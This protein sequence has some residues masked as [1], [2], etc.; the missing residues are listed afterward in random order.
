MNKCWAILFLGLSLSLAS[1][2]TLAQQVG[3]D[4]EV[5]VAP[6]Y[7]AE[8]GNQESLY[9]KRL[10]HRAL[11][12]TVP[13]YG[14]FELRLPEQLLV[15]NRLRVSVQRGVVD[16]MWRNSVERADNGLLRVPVSLLGELTQYRMLLVRERDLPLYTDPLALSDLR[17]RVAGV[18]AQW[19]DVK[20]LA[21]NQ[22][23]YVTATGYHPL[24]R[25]LAADRFDYF[26]RG[27]YQVRGEI[28]QY[29]E[30][31]LAMVPNL[32]L[33]YPND[34][35]FYV[36]PDNPKLAKR[37]TLGLERAQRDGSLDALIDEFDRLRWAKEQISR[38]DW[39]VIY[40][41]SPLPA[42]QRR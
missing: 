16:V 10:L 5:I 4:V 32:V 30:L 40:L 11:Q 35:Y 9:F 34:V 15:D 12:L 7:G 31:D 36:S 22:L 26:P 3:G 37:L 27:I 8:D 13:E 20:V 21:H 25:M 2:F 19:P 6:S 42:P 24:F 33:S 18:G 17:Q 29:P 28:E 1:V 41:D 38:A 14:E 39:Q 23:P